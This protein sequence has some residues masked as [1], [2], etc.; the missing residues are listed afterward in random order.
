MTS[1]SMLARDGL[2]SVFD[3]LVTDCLLDMANAGGPT[4]DILL[5]YFIY[6]YN[7]GQEDLRDAQQ[8]EWRD[9]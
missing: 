2:D 5:G 6:C 7:R 8:E 1:V 9:E 4:N 3:E